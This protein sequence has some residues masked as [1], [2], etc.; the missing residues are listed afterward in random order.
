MRSKLALS[1]LALLTGASIVA[2]AGDTSDFTPAR[3]LSGSTPPLPSLNTIGSIQ[4][5]LELA[6]GAS[7]RV[8]GVTAAHATPGPALVSPAVADWQFQPATESGRAVASRVLVA[9]IVRAPEW[10]DDVISS[11]VPVDLT[12]RSSEIPFPTAMTAPAY[13][14]FAVAGAVAIVEVLVDPDGRVSAAR[15]VNRAAGFESAALSA[16]RAWS[17]QP[18]QRN[19]Q[20]VP[21][22]VYLVFG[23]RPPVSAPR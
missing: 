19:G 1:V 12:E 13:P 11:T 2:H 23:F 7:G 15:L 3:R 6:V 22:Y 9:A 4:E 21:A 16:A 20:P 17:F 5:S 8:Q 18:A 14:P 10:Y